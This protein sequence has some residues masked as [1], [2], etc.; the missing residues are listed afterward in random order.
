MQNTI[1]MVNVWRLMRINKALKIGKI[2]LKITLKLYGKF[3]S[4]V[5]R[6]IQVIQVIQITKAA[7]P[8]LGGA[9]LVGLI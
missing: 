1:G 6:V 4:P 7:L 2:L 3:T 8:T 5:V 9:T